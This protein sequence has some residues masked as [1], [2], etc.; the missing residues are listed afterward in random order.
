MKKSEILREAKKI[1]WNG[2]T[3]SIP[4]Y[5]QKFICLAINQVPAPYFVRDGL[6]QWIQRDLLGSG[7]YATLETWLQREGHRKMS[8][9]N[10]NYRKMQATRHAWIDWMIQHWE[11]KGE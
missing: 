2:E 10:R 4:F 6:K 5:Q 7:S 8:N 9:G 11:G 3:R 1:L